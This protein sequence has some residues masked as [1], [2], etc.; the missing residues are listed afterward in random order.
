MPI[1]KS[2]KKRV[3]TARAATI[4]NQRT[5]RALRINLKEFASS[6]KSGKKLAESHAAAQS[7]LDTAAKKGLINKNQLAR[8]KRQLA[9]M[10]KIPAGAKKAAK[11]VKPK[12]SAQKIVKKTPPKKPSAKKK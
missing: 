2:A 6:V 4:R 10:A 5:K 7:A 11:V 1:I 12:P 3:R 9:K 8:K